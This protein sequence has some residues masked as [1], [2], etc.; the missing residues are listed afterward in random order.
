MASD[1]DPDD[2]DDDPE[3]DLSSNKSLVKDDSW[4][5]SDTEQDVEEKN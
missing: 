5:P 2:D 3:S 4:I 1:H